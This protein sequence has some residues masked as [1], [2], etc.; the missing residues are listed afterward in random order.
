MMKHQLKNWQIITHYLLLLNLFTKERW[1][2][3][4]LVN[5]EGFYSSTASTTE[6]GESQDIIEIHFQ[7][8]FPP[9]LAPGLPPPMLQAQICP[10]TGY[11]GIPYS[12]NGGTVHAIVWMFFTGPP[13][14]K[15]L[16]EQD[17]SIPQSFTYI[18]PDL[19]FSHLLQQFK[20]WHH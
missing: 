2:T 14:A 17:L 18:S 11:H 8:G 20:A 5:S 1:S 9:C 10:A 16:N 19:Y 6:H 4:T 3:Q 13:T 7:T 12:P 15:S